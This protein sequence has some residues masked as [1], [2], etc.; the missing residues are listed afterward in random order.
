MSTDFIQ[1][2]LRPDLI[3][4]NLR[5]MT[6]DDVIRELLDMMEQAGCLNDRAEAERAVLQRETVMS[7]GWAQGVA[8]PHAKTRAV[9]TLVAALGIKRDGVDFN[10][11]DGH[12]ARI[13]MLVLYPGKP[14]DPGLRF[15]SGF[16]R[17]TKQEE[18]QEKLYHARSPQEIH[19]ILQQHDH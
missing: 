18:M 16:I 3:S 6:R 8:T 7:T 9:N 2:F 13:I 15:I 11:L 14:T 10:S 17:I 12:K 19:E 4:A 5:S 1:S